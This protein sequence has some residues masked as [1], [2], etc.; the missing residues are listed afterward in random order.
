MVSF[1]F[2]FGL[3][4]YCNVFGNFLSA[5]GENEYIP[6][7]VPCSPLN[8]GDK[9]NTVCTE[10]C[11]PNKKCFCKPGYLRNKQGICIK[12]PECGKFKNVY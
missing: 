12:K 5:C 8:C 2:S 9:N 1:K 7:C 4:Y 11:K 10:E 3:T 6:E